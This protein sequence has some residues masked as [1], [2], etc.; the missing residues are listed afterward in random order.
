MEQAGDIKQ[1]ATEVKQNIR[2]LGG[3]LRDQA[4]DYYEQGRQQARE[5]EQGLESYVREKPIRALAI[6]AGIGVLLG[7]LWKRS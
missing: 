4:Q 6:A 3:Q 5:W 2:E 7:I 1:A